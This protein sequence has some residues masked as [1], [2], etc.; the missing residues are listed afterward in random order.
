[1]RESLQHAR[2]RIAKVCLD[3]QQM[4]EAPSVGRPFGSRGI[5]ATKPLNY[6]E[7]VMF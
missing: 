2:P 5:L 7:K 1:M 3:G 6:I 4:A